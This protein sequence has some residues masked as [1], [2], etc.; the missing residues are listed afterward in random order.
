MEESDFESDSFNEVREYRSDEDVPRRTSQL[1]KGN[2]YPR[3]SPLELVTVSR[4]NRG[5]PIFVFNNGEHQSH[6]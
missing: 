1:I 4:N 5:N 3:T 2:P 6:V